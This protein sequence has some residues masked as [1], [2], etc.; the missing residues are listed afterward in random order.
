MSRLDGR[1]YRLVVKIAGRTIVGV[2]PVATSDSAR[3]TP[4]VEAWLAAAPLGDRRSVTPF[5]PARK[6]IRRRDEHGADYFQVAE[7][8]ATATD[9]ITG[10]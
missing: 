9:T 6:L 2:V 4:D 8:L 7:P 1:G 5:R 3:H 10:E